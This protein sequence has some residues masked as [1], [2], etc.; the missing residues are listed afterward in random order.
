MSKDGN[1]TVQP[2]PHSAIAAGADHLAYF[3]LLGRIA[4]VAAA[5]TPR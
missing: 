3:A 5:G 2:N 1:R 4:G